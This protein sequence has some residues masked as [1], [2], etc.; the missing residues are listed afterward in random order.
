[1]SA[2]GR[3]GGRKAALSRCGARTR[4]A[5]ALGWNQAGTKEEARREECRALRAVRNA[6]TAA[7]FVL[8]LATPVLAQATHLLVITGVAGDEE[9]AKQ[10][11]TWAT[12]FIDAAK[13]RDGVAGGTIT[14]LAE[15]SDADPARIRGRSTRENVDKTFTAIAAQAKPNDEVF[16]LL[17][18]HGSFDG[19]LAAFN[20]PGPDLTAND[21]AKLL[22]K[23]ATQRVA[24]INTSSS[25]G[26]FSPA[27][28]GPG[29]VIVTATKSGGERN[30]TRFPRFFVEAFGD[31]T[32][33]ADRNG[34]VSV[35]EAFDYAR[36]KV[37]KAYAQDGL[38]LTEHAVLDD[39]SDGKLA[40]TLFLA[41]SPAMT[42]SNID[43]SDPAIRALVAERDALDKRIAELKL[44]KDGMEPARY[45]TELERLL[46]DLAVKT[47]AIRALQAKKDA[48]P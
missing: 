14:Y 4:G 8:G 3:A 20:L 32:A 26:A 15:K 39:G 10:F 22:G 37:V 34:R 40:A 9:H 33:D 17:I 2:C 5:T 19:R 48:K 21:W 44:A 16:V 31:Q 18:G 23:L 35:L 43:T 12:T 6:V 36:A 29:R 45:E 30:E 27:V 25:S 38:L 13:K 1:M 42:A 28:T 41:T 24:F 47:K 46:T 11:H 7:L